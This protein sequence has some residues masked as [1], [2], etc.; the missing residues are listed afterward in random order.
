MSFQKAGQSPA[1]LFLTKLP[2]G[3]GHK[4]GTIALP[5][6]LFIQASL[7]ALNHILEELRGAGM[8]LSDQVF[9][10]ARGNDLTTTGAAFGA[11]VNNPIRSLDHIQVMLDNDDGIAV[12]TQPVDDFQQLLDIMKVET[13]R[14][15]IK[16]V[17]RFAGI[18]FRELTRKFNAL[19]FSSGEGC[20]ALA[21]LDVTKTHVHQGL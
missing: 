2:W 4:T 20:G 13:G 11:K 5:A 1:F 7:R 18:A 10:T 21:E 12:I 8:F 14:W 19:C 17:E 3:L 9:G 15:F 6:E 16:Y